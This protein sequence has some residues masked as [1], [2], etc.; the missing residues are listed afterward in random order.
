MKTKSVAAEPLEKQL[1]KTAEKLRKNVDAAD[2]KHAVS[3]LIFLNY[4]SDFFEEHFAKLQ[5]EEG[6]CAGADP[7]DKDEYR[8]ENVL[9]VP[10]G[11]RC[12]LL[13]AKARS[14]DVLG[15]VFAYFLGEFSLAEG[16]K[17]GQ[18]YTPRSIVELW[19]AML[20]PY[21]GRVFDHCCGSGEMFGQSEK[22]VEER[23]GKIH[24][25]SIYGRESNQ[26]TWLLVKMNLAIRGIDSSQVK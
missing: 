22:F 19:V 8:A 2:Y 5:A 11:A 26:S 4:I 23:Q 9:F 14:R 1:W 16:K 13:L 3:A 18:F 15:R 12:S 20:E 6:D 7:E 25:I 10:K 21:R 17:G 24:D